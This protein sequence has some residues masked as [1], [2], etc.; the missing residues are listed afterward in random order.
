MREAGLHTPEPQAW[1][2]DAD[3]FAARVDFLFRAERV[4]VEFEG[5]VKYQSAQDLQHE[6]VRE[7]ALRRL[8]YEVVRITWADLESTS[9]VSQLIH[10]AVSRSRARAA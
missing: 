2:R 1:V 8:G 7:D 10:E 6:K 4:I 3:G 9:R 5:M